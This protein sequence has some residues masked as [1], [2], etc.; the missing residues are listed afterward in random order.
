MCE[1]TYL[2]EDKINFKSYIMRTILRQII[3]GIFLSVAVSSVVSAQQLNMGD[4]L[5][6][7]TNVR[8]GKLDNGMGYYLRHNAKS[9]GLAD[10][11]I[12]YDVGSVQEEDSQNGLAHFLEHMMFNGTKHFPDDSMILWLESIGMQFGTN[13]N[14]ATGMEMTYYQL[15]QVPLKRESIVD[16]MLLILHDW[17]GYLALEDKKIDKERGVIIEELRQRNNAQFRVGN[18][19][20]IPVFGDTRY[21]HRNM[22]GTEEFLRTFDSQMLRD[23]YKCWYRPD[24][25]AVVIVGDFDVNE[26]EAKLKKVMADIPV[27]QNPKAKEVIRIP[28]NVAPVVTVIT[29]PEQQTCNAN[30]YI[31]RAAVPKELNNRVGATYMNMMINIAAAMMNTRFGELAQQEGCPFASAHLQN[32]PLT[33]TCDALELQVVARGDAIA[34]AFTSAYG[35]LERVRRF[36]FTEEELEQVRTGI[37]RGGKYAYETAGDRENGM[38]VWECINHYVK[39]TP[40]M[41]PQHKW[42]VTQLMLMKQVTLQEVNELVRQLISLANN[43]LVI[44]APEKA[45]RVLPETE[46]LENFFSWVRTVE[47]EPYQTEKI[48]RPLLSE[49]IISG[50]VIKTKKG[51]YGSTVWMLENGIRVVVLPTTD[52]PYQIVMSGQAS[53]GLSMIPTEDYYSVSMLAQVVSASGV[54]DFTAEQLRKVLGSKVVNIQPT[55]NRFSTDINGSAAKGDVETMLQLTYLYFTRPNFDRGRLDMVIEANRKNLENSVNSPDFVMTQMVNKITYGDQQRTRIPDEQILAGIDCGKISSWYRNLFTD[56]AGNYTFYFV[57]DIDME[58]FK[59]LVEKYIGGLPAGKQQ[60]GWK[61]DGVR[62]LPG[63]KEERQ[64]IRMETARSMVS[65]GYSGGMDYTQQNMMTMGM[66]SACLQSRY[67]QIIREEKGGSYGVSVNGTLSRQPI[68]TYDL[69][70][71]FQTNPD[72]VEELVRVVKDELFQIADKGPDPEDLNKHLEYWRKMET[73]NARNVQT[74]LILLQTYY[75]WGEDWDVDY[76]KL[77][78]SITVE[79]VQE[80]ARKIM[81]DGNLKEVVVNPT[82]MVTR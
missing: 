17:S 75:T 61:D 6:Q 53:G 55:I 18:K 23:F 47:M 66:L 78:N 68:G 65:I 32:V 40:L 31:R 38:L 76:N 9:T 19:A 77:L 27:A 26:M 2:T 63:V 72:M 10:F 5:P 79:K 52:T 64:E 28:D 22:L 60:L 43:V 73:Q 20:A 62:V 36:G 67:N 39:N 45:K 46:I 13:L 44:S 58:T 25:Q 3:L 74:R 34:E 48:D 80:L 59:P 69:K 37:L 51:K 41:S 57:G 42:A 71:T 24:L 49:E 82:T 81:A 33:N 21:A 14:A 50:R 4:I 54:G 8:V 7:D 35:E 30:F 15:T 16:S 70:V 56:A 29:D 1:V 11:Y 12:V